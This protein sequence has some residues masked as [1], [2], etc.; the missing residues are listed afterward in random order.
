MWVKVMVPGASWWTDLL[1]RTYLTALASGAPAGSGVPWWA[2]WLA[3]AW[4]AL[5]QAGPDMQLL[6]AH[7]FCPK[8]LTLVKAF[9]LR[10]A[11]S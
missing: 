10:A 5:K 6:P 7:C 9:C 1:W 3:N 11:S 2:S 4:M 8:N